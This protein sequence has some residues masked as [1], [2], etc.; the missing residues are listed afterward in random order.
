ME[1][2]P[3]G[4]GPRVDLDYW[5]DN[6]TLLDWEGPIPS[7]EPGFAATQHGLPLDKRKMM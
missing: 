1:I 5:R 4:G 3:V 7:E 2:V 6:L